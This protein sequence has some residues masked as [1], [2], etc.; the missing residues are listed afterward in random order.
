MIDKILEEIIATEVPANDV[1]ILL[2]GGVDSLSLAFGAH[3]LGKKITAY[4]FYLEGDKSYDACKAEEACDVFGWD[5]KTTVINPERLRDDF[6]LLAKQYDCRKKTQFEC[7][8]PFLFIFP[9][10]TQRY[11]MS[12]I[13]ADGH[14]GL[15]KKAILHFREPKE[16]FDEFRERYFRGSN[17]AGINQLLQLSKE[18]S[19]TL[20]HPYLHNP[21]VQNFYKQYNWFELNTPK[22]KNIVRV[23]YQEEFSKLNK[24][25]EHINLQLGAN[26]DHLFETLLKDKR[27][28]NRGRT[29][30]MDLASDYAS[31]GSGTLLL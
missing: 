3:R 30:I 27:L 5:C 23:A 7:T 6:I 28:N 16:L 24:V 31:Q 21:I 9:K 20:V 26:I 14:Y 29:R 18:Y 13:A 17:I 11:V 25:K 4:T 10:I 12:G 15:S 2:S 8:Y 19:K 22:Q 1:A